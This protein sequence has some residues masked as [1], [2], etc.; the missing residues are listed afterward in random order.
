MLREIGVVVLGTHPIGQEG[1]AILRKP[2][3]VPGLL[4]LPIC[5][6]PI[7]LA[8][9]RSVT[10]HYSQSH[11]T[12]SILS[13]YYSITQR[14]NAVQWNSNRD[15]RVHLGQGVQGPLKPSGAQGSLTALHNLQQSQRGFSCNSSFPQSTYTIL[16]KFFPATAIFLSQPT[17]ISTR[18]SYNTN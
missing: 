10:L 12:L 4:C 18:F 3:G 7:V 14:C 13:H 15:I 16:K 2:R 5:Y 9:H 1:A 11:V 17:A 6:T 8:S